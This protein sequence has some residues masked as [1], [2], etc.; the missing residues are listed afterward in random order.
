M[1]YSLNDFVQCTFNTL[2]LLSL[3]R[4]RAA[5]Q[6][7]P[8]DTTVFSKDEDLFTEKVWKGLKEKIP[9]GPQAIGLDIGFPAYQRPYGIPERINSFNI[10]PTVDYHRVNEKIK[11]VREEEPMRLFTCDHFNDKYPNHSQYGAVPILHMRS[12]DIKSMIGIYW[13]NAADTFV[14]I[15][16]I[17]DQKHTH[18]MSETGHL[19]VFIFAGSSPSVVT[20]KQSLLTGSAPLPP[21]WVLGYH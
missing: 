6:R 4:A 15:I 16:Q 9:Y 1:S 14:D 19:Q 12:E 21:N 5:N 13:C 10:K 7:Y 20:Y 8:H 11:K 18:W 3:E 17:D 2:G